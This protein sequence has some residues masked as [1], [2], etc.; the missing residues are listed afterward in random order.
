MAPL[1]ISR[2]PAAS[3][4][5]PG[6]WETSPTACWRTD[7]RRI[8]LTIWPIATAVAIA[9]NQKPG[10]TLGP[11]RDSRRGRRSR[12]CAAAGRTPNRVA[13][14][15]RSDSQ[16]VRAGP[17]DDFC[18]RGIQQCG[19]PPV[20]TCSRLSSFSTATPPPAWT[21]PSA[22][23]RQSARLLRI[24]LKPSEQADRASLRR[25]TISIAQPFEGP[26]DV[27]ASV[28]KRPRPHGLGSAATT[29]AGGAVVRRCRC[30]ST[31]C[32]SADSG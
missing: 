1:R 24:G 12:R 27:T 3:Q 2:S 31:A 32:W 13:F 26:K 22:G 25:T 14:S 15:F 4:A 5:L 29:S 20:R 30:R 17:D 6:G 28:R 16:R 21:P 9:Q 18:I 7:L 11:A 8:Q 23:E 10:G 19:D